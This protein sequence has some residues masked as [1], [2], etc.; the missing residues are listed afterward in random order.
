M[1]T[2]SVLLIS[3]DQKF[4]SELVQHLPEQF[5]LN[6]THVSLR[7]LRESLGIAKPLVI[8]WDGRNPQT[9]WNYPLRWIRERFRGRPI[10]AILNQVEDERRQE[11]LKLGV[12][13]ILHRSSSTFFE[14]LAKHIVAVVNDPKTNENNNGIKDNFIKYLNNS[15]CL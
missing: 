14:D 13:F 8:L 4:A 15:M 3:E 1:N 5:Q 11:L 10:V 9:D 12:N 2:T 6:I 7:D